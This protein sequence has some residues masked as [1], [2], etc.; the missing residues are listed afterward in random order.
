MGS[1]RTLFGAFL[2]VL[3]AMFQGLAAEISQPEL[4][5]KDTQ[6]RRQGL[7]AYRGRVVVLNFWATWCGPCKEEMPMLQALAAFREHSKALLTEIAPNSWNG[8]NTSPAESS[9][10]RSPDRLLL[11]GAAF[12]LKPL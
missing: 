4:S 5:L 10:T 1:R 11:R 3:C 9:R 7:K 6:G 8:A 2:F 12:R